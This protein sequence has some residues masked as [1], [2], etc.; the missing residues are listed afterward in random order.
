MRLLSVEIR[1]EGCIHPIK[2]APGI[3]NSMIGVDPLVT[4]LSFHS[5]WLDAKHLRQMLLKDPVWDCS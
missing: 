1:P 2:L 5:E 4:I 3:S